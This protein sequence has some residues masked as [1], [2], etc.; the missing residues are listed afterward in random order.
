MRDKRRRGSRRKKCRIVRGKEEGECS[1][2]DGEKED[3]EG[4]RREKRRQEGVKRDDEKPNRR[5]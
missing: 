5:A 4:K 1:Q 2:T 3:G